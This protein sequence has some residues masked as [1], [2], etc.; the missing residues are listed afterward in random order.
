MLFTPT[1][2]T[3]FATLPAASR[4]ESFNLRQVSWTLGEAAGSWCGGSIFLFCLNRGDGRAY[5]LSL[6]TVALIGMSAVMVR[7]TR[8]RRAG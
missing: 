3:A 2:S 4:L 7:V 5:W 6:G 1:V 8:S